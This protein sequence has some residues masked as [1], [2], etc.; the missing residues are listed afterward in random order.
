MASRVAAAKV[1]RNFSQYEAEALVAPVTV[2]K[3]GRPSVVIL[4]ATEYTR[5]KKLDRRAL[6]VAE[7]TDREMA[8]IRRARVPAKHRY[9]LSDLK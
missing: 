3:G 8:A 9:A 4:A 6:A 2:V 1:E 5:L 7:L